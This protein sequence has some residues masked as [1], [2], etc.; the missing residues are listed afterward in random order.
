MATMHAD[1]HVASSEHLAPQRRLQE[2][3]HALNKRGWEQRL[4][5][6]ATR[7]VEK[8]LA[9]ACGI[10]TWRCCARP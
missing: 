1:P 10:W 2:C 8:R 6:L 7:M 5:L 9:R 4:H 3:L